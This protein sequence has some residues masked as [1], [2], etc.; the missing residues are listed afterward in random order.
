M[1]RRRWF[2]SL[3]VA[4]LAAGTT[5][6]GGAQAHEAFRPPPTPVDHCM[7]TISVPGAYVL[8]KDLVCGPQYGVEIAASNVDF[9]MHGHSVD[10]QTYPI[11][12]GTTN[13]VEHVVVRGPGQVTGAPW[14]GLR[15]TNA[16]E[17]IVVGIEAT[18]NGTGLFQ[19]YGHASDNLFVFNNAHD[20]GARGIAIWEGTDTFVG[21]NRCSSNGSGIILGEFATSVTDTDVIGNRCTDNTTFGIYNGPQGSANEIEWNRATGNGFYDLYDAQPGCDAN[22]WEHNFFDTANQPCIH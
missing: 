12:V 13:A 22:T 16:T 14:E 5:G 17:S 2:L 3:L 10:S 9:D 19:A 18:R 21:F 20:N 6:V 7:Y 4:A 15:L 1:S 8:T 11:N